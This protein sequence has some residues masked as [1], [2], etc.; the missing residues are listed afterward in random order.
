MNLENYSIQ[1]KSLFLFF[2]LFCCTSCFIFHEQ[3]TAHLSHECQVNCITTAELSK[4]F[5][6]NSEKVLFVL[7]SMRSRILLMVNVENFSLSSFVTQQWWAKSLKILWSRSGDAWSWR[8]TVS[9]SLHQFHPFFGISL[10]SR[11]SNVF[12][13]WETIIP[14]R[15]ARGGSKRADVRPWLIDSNFDA[16]EDYVHFAGSLR[17]TSRRCKHCDKI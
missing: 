3:N 17:I 2:F 8:F 9:V 5:D 7:L 12:A 13:K 16:E 1:Q 11:T 14:V 4:Y 15:A 6:S 10:R